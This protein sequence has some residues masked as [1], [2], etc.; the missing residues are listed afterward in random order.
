[1]GDLIIY[2]HILNPPKLKYKDRD[3]E[4]EEHYLSNQRRAK[5]HEDSVAAAR[6]LKQADHPRKLSFKPL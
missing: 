2:W 6:K 1:M 5:A 4:F 3:T